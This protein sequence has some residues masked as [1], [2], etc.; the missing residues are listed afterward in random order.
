VETSEHYRIKH[1]THILLSHAL[2]PIAHRLGLLKEE[3]GLT[4]AIAY[5][6]LLTHAGVPCG[7]VKSAYL[8]WCWKQKALQQLKA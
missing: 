8:R 6:K 2:V 1:Q 5:C 7:H 4:V 3:L